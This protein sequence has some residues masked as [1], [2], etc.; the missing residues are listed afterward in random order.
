MSTLRV[1]QIV[2][3]SGES[4]EFTNGVSFGPGIDVDNIAVNSVGIFTAT[5]LSATTIN[6]SGVCTAAFF[7]GDTGY[8][9][10][11]ET[12]TNL[13]G[14]SSGKVIGLTFIT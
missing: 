5:T 13:P 8:S 14:A 9:P 1:N 11:N 6:S 3:S 12:L 4:V 10:G 2:G 7:T